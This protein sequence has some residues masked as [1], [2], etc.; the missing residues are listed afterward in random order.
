[1]GG[2]GFSYQIHRDP[3]SVG[4]LEIIKRAFALGLRAI[5]T[6][7][8]YE[9]SEELLGEALGHVD[10]TS[11]YRRDDYFLMTKVGRISTDHFDYSPQWIQ[12]SVARSLQRLKTNYLNVVFCHDVEFVTL[13]EA[14]DAVGTLFTISSQGQIERVGI[15]GYDIQRLAAVASGAREKYGRPVDVVQN[16]A[17][18]TLQNS[19]LEK[20]GFEA[21]RR[22]GVSVVCS[23]SPLA[24][25]L[26]RLDGVP[27]GALGDWHPAPQQLR[28]VSRNAAEWMRR[29]GGSLES[30]ALRYS[31]AKAMRA[32]VD[33][34]EVSI[35]IGVGAMSDL[36][37]NVRTAKEILKPGHKDA[38]ASTS[39]KSLE[40]FDVLNEDVEALD[41]PLYHSIQQQMGRWLDYDLVHKARI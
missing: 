38:N 15:S 22:A 10:I 34:F 18:L 2:S 26:L 21:F 6:S 8:Y 27:L 28:E 3:K 23:S 37:E 31:I 29:N 9:P 39:C 11:R 1:M 19:Q 14:I 24:S 7:P 5:D 35:I 40:L 16:W 33:G 4:A 17:Q 32:S 36:D 25:G 12:K 30:L 20:I 13:A 41:A